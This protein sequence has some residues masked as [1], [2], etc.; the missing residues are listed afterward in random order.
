[1]KEDSIDQ[2]GEYV[3]LPCRN[4]ASQDGGEPSLK[5]NTVNEESVCPRII[6]LPCWKNSEL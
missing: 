2:S 4:T 3:L 5:T 6:Q 1:M